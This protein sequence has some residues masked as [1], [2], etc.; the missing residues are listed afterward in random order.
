MLRITLFSVAVLIAQSSFACDGLV[1]GRAQYEKNVEDRIEQLS[2]QLQNYQKL[3]N[4]AKKRYENDKIQV[5]QDGSITRISPDGTKINSN[6]E[7]IEP[8]SQQIADAKQEL[9]EAKEQQ[10]IS[11]YVDLVKYEEAYAS[12]AKDRP[13]PM[14]LGI[15]CGSYSIKECTHKAYNL[16]KK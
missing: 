13:E 9:Q 12:C 14:S 7:F 10:P 1:G 2:E 15:P 4:E 16:S 6:Y 3:H 5:E 11:K 8:Y